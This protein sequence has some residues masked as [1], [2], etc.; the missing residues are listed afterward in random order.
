[1]IS[2]VKNK[3][4]DYKT[5]IE[6]HPMVA[7]SPEKFLPDSG[8]VNAFWFKTTDEKAVGLGDMMGFIGPPEEIKTWVFNEF[9]MEA[10]Q[11]RTKA[12][13]FEVTSRI[14]CLRKLKKNVSKQI[15]ILE[16]QVPPV[17]TKNER[18]NKIDNRNQKG[19]NQT[20]ARNPIAGKK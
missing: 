15:E 1:M 8:Y 7:C 11:L 18:H 6:E 13:D 2:M 16:S 10:I 3:N 12:V 14:K 17:E 4:S 9:S 19:T 5:E 20:S